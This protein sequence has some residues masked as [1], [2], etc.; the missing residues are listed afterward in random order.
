VRRDPRRDAG[1]RAAARRRWSGPRPAPRGPRRADPAV[2]PP[3][4]PRRRH[5]S[6]R[7]PRG[8]PPAAGR[9][10][11]GRAAPRAGDDR[12]RSRVR[13]ARDRAGAPGPGQRAPVDGR[14][15]RAR[16]R[17]V[18][19]ALAGPDRGAARST[20]H[21]G[22][23]QQRVD[24]AARHV[25]HATVPAHR[26]RGG[27][28]RSTPRRAR[29]PARRRAQGSPPREPDGDDGRAAQRDPSDCGADLGRDE[30]HVRAPCAGDPRPAG[31]PRR[32]DLPHG[33][34]RDPGRGARR[35]PAQRPHRAWPG[36][37]GSRRGL[38]R[39]LG[40]LAAC[41]GG[42]PGWST[43]TGPGRDRHRGPV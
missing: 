11:P 3:D 35:E 39:S 6:P 26:R 31:G 18:P 42:I 19:R 22:G 28:H 16:R 13:G 12:S 34:R 24:R 27:G 40:H 38:R 36:A 20:R 23:D 5:P 21:G 41:P 15:V 37:F 9:T 10:L 8:R 17:L 25:R 43:N 32:R 14:S 30:Q 33:P 7:R 2:G 4:R 29:A 1:G